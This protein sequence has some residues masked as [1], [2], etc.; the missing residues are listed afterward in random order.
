MYSTL[1][2]NSGYPLRDVVYLLDYYFSKF[3]KPPLSIEFMYLQPKPQV[4]A[5][6]NEPWFHPNPMGKNTLHSLLGTVCVEVGI[7][8]KKSNHSLRATE[9]MG[10]FA[11]Q[12]QTLPLVKKLTS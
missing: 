12:V 5:D 2:V 11:A 1:V 7:E 3:P 10:M 6:P 8:E 4:P 9:A